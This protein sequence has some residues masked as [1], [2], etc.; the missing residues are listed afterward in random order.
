MFHQ[1]PTDN[2]EA[3]TQQHQKNRLTLAM[4]DPVTTVV[5]GNA[6]VSAVSTEWSLAKAFAG[7]EPNSVIL[8]KLMGYASNNGLYGATAGPVCADSPLLGCLCRTLVGPED[9]CAVL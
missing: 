4:V 5:A 9:R 7:S 8:T 1:P 2:Y 6:A 3:T